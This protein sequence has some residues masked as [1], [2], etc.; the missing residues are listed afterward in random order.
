MQDSDLG[1]GPMETDIPKAKAHKGKDT[2]TL[3]LDFDESDDDVFDEEAK[4]LGLLVLP[5]P[6][7]ML[8]LVRKFHVNLRRVFP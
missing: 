8:I 7:L 5:N 6:P 3:T 2:T 4:M 1:G